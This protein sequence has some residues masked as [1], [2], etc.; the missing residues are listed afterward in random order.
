LNGKDLEI[1]DIVEITSPMKIITQFFTNA[2]LFISDNNKIVKMSRLRVLD[3]KVV[4]YYAVI[5]E[6][7]PYTWEVERFRAWHPGVRFGVGFDDP[8]FTDFDSNDQPYTRLRIVDE[9]SSVP[10]TIT[11]KY[12][13]REDI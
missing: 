6:A 9:Y 5:D 8:N 7:S 4:S 12:Y 11:L 10:A 13:L 2:D 3:N 1:T